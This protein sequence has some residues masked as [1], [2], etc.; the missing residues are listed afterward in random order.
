MANYAFSDRGPY[1]VGP[2]MVVSS[3]QTQTFSQTAPQLIPVDRFRITIGLQ[4]D[5]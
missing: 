2:L 1:T 3:S 5:F 4:A